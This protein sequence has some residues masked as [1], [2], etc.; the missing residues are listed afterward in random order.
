MNL[1]KRKRTNQ[2]SNNIKILSKLILYNKVSKK[3]CTLTNII[4]I[5]HYVIEIFI[6]NT[7]YV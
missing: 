5:N 7:Y 6:L 4:G 3:N 2:H 1:K